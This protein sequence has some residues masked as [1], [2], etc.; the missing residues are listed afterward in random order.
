MEQKRTEIG[1]LGEFGLINRLTSSFQLVN[2]ESIL[3]IGDD[4]A[5]LDFQDQILVSTDLLVEGVHFDMAYTPLKHL[6]YKAI[7]V[8]VS[9]IAAMYGQATQVLV[10]L[11]VSNRFSVEALEEFYEG[12]QAACKNYGVDLVG[13]DTSSSKSGLVINVTVLGKANK[14]HIVKRSGAKVGDL[15]YVSGDLGGALMGLHLLER[16]KEVYLS[17]NEIQ[18]DLE[19]KNYIVE[20]LLKPEARTD[21][22]FALQDAELV[23]TSMMDI[24]DGLASELHHIA[25]NSG[26]GFEIYDEYLPIDQ[27][28]YDTALEFNL[29]PSVCALNGGEDYELVMTFNPQDRKKLD[30]IPELIQIGEVVDSSK[31]LTLITKSAQRIPLTAQ[32]WVHFN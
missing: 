23:P 17:N 25:K 22:V 10:S 9:D 11:A 18:P 7:A 27:Q 29:D 31:G 2:Q 5:V 21:V 24:S 14:N 28:T 13:G 3:G 26:V 30:Q 16:E 1:T 8:N 12:V 20:R 32:A 19:E 4:C 6:G 15:V